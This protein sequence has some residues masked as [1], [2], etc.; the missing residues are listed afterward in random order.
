MAALKPLSENSNI[1]IFLGLVSV[2]FFLV[3]GF[4]GLLETGMGEKGQNNI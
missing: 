2:V 1:C 3:L 4:S